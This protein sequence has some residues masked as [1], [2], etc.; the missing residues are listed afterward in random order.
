MFVSFHRNIIHGS[1]SVESAQKEINLWFKPAELIDFKPCAHDWI[2]EWRALP[3][4]CAFQHLI[5]FQLLPESKPGYLSAESDCQ[6]NGCEL[7][8]C[9]AFTYNRP[10]FKYSAKS[11]YSFRNHWSSCWTQAV[12]NLQRESWREAGITSNTARGKKGYPKI[13]LL[14]QILT[15]NEMRLSAKLALWNVYLIHPLLSNLVLRAS[16]SLLSHQH[17]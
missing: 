13:S 12:V 11:F 6:I 10:L 15:L 7:I 5:S 4:I 17:T 2:Y 1:D 16:H 14:T 8:P 3:V 9:G